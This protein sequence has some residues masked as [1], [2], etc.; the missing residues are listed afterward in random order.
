MTESEIQKKIVER[1]GEIAHI[2]A[3]NRDCE[4]RRDQAKI[5]KII[6]VDKTEVK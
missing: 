3:K 1:S 6:E 2:L 5:V 4:L